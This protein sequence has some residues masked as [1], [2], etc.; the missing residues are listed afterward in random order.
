MKH[1]EVVSKISN[2]HSNGK[3]QEELLFN[4][5]F[6]CSSGQILPMTTLSISQHVELISEN[7]KY[8][9]QVEKTTTTELI[10]CFALSLGD[11]MWSD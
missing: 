9:L 10:E 6:D 2:H 8:K 5:S 1:F 11:S 3:I 7:I 4:H